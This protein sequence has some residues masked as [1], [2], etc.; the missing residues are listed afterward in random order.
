MKILSPQRWLPSGAVSK[1]GNMA[2]IEFVGGDQRLWL[3]VPVRSL[4]NLR[5]LCERLEGMAIDA[6]KG[7]T[8]N[9][10]SYCTVSERTRAVQVR[11]I[12]GVVENQKFKGAFH[13]PSL[14]D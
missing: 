8:S 3:T 5:G 7:I 2:L 1:D 14:S 4:Q 9:G 11:A 13:G 12:K 6:S 10:T